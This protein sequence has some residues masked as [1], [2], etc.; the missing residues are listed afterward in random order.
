M[1]HARSFSKTPGESKDDSSSSSTS[2]ASESE[3]VRGLAFPLIDTSVVPIHV[4]LSQLE[5]DVKL[6]QV[7]EQLILDYLPVNDTDDA[8]DNASLL[9]E[10]PGSGEDSYSSNISTVTMAS[11]YRKGVTLFGNLAAV[12]AIEA[13][14]EVIADNADA[15]EKL[16]A[17]NPFICS[18]VVRVKDH[19]GNWLE[20]NLLMLAAMTGNFNPREPSVPEAHY[21][22]F[23]K[24]SFYYPPE[25]VARVAEIVNSA[26][27][28]AETA[29]RMQPYVDASDQFRRNLIDND[30]NS[31]GFDALKV[32]YQLAIKEFK[33]KLKTNLNQVIKLGYVFDLNVIASAL[34]KSVAN[35]AALGGWQSW[36]INVICVV[37]AGSFQKKASACDGR[38]IK[39]GILPVVEE[40]VLPDRD[41]VLNENNSYHIVESPHGGRSLVL[42]SDFFWDIGAAGGCRAVASR[43]R[44]V[45]VGHA[46]TLLQILCRAKTSACSKFMLQPGEQS[47]QSCCAI[48]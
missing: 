48:M 44:Y 13:A 30:T 31:L 14:Y 26:E 9:Q 35:I 4:P 23:E 32:R 39:R 22:I 11:F 17:K 43:G 10:L 41:R 18:V 2:A 28:K 19:D 40:G 34:E 20:G 3:T 45:R 33:D 37:V 6:P 47:N 27:W 36:K 29:R 15:V 24:L 5:P 12:K 1:A 38:I 25:E 16:V 8:F 7:I 21:G 46:R 42:G